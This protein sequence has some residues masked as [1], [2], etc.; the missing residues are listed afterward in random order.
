MTYKNNKF[1]VYGLGISGISTAKYLAQNNYNIIA[2]DDNLLALENFR[3]KIS[4]NFSNIQI[5]NPHQ[6]IFDSQ[7]IISFSPGIPLHFPTTHKILDICYKTQAKLKCDIAIFQDLNPQNNYIGITGTNGKSTTTALTGFI[8]DQLKIPSAIGGNIGLPCFDLPQN[9]VNF[10]YIF[11]VSSYQLDLIPD[12]KFNIACLTNI[13]KDHIDRHGTFE[14]YQKSKERIFQNQTADDFAIINRDNIY[15]QKIYQNLININHPASLISIS[16]QKILENGISII[17][18]NIF[19]NLQKQKFKFTFN[20]FIKGQHNLENIAFA[21]AISVC[22]LIKNHQFSEI[23]IHEI[24]KIIE[25]FT[26]LKHRLQNIRFHQNINFINDSKAT[27]AESTENAL[28]SYNNIFWILGGKAKEGGISILK[29]YF[30]KISKAYLI[31]E[32]ADDFAK[33]LQQNNV[34]FEIS[35]TLET[36]FKSA[37]QDALKVNSSTQNIILSPACA[38]FD[39]WKNF[40]ERGD[41]FCKLVN[42]I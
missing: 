39:Q 8:F 7:T 11:E 40:E 3:Q 29:P 17:N 20:P 12:N 31:G 26:G 21:L 25:K 42:E 28:K 32:S 30:S 37:Y 22:Y 10:N 2:T 13:T 18:E 6:I 41:F 14:N 36:A 35:K 33:F 16:T 5:L 27:N 4:K 24:I 38:S 15:C 23:K 9:Q 34:V 1:V 19:V